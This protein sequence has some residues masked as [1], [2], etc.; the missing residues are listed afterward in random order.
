MIVSLNITWHVL[1]EVFDICSLGPDICYNF[2]T[3]CVALK[4]MVLYS[5]LEM[6]CLGVKQ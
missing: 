1:A 6:L 2:L 5:L 3:L 4:H